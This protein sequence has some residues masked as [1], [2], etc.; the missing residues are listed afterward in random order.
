MFPLNTKWFV[1]AACILWTGCTCT[2]THSSVWMHGKAT[3]LQT[4][5]IE[6]MQLLP[7]LANPSGVCCLVLTSATPFLACTTVQNPLCKHAIWMSYGPIGRVL[8]VCAKSNW[9]GNDNRRKEWTPSARLSIKGKMNCVKTW[10]MASA[11]VKIHWCCTAIMNS[12]K[13]TDNDAATTCFC[14]VLSNQH[15][16]IKNSCLDTNKREC[17]VAALL[18][19]Q[20]F[21]FVKF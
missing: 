6:S 7:M 17:S 19:K 5:E 8:R 12:V 13:V 3:F 21:G 11:S 10:F 1:N 9:N 14:S 20:N 18:S 15:A 4:A 2:R 16:T